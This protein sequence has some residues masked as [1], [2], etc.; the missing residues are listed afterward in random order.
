MK[1]I[2]TDPKLM[3]ESVN[4]YNKSIKSVKGTHPKHKNITI[5]DFSL[6]NRGPLED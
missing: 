5:V 1:D 3:H 2:F 4:K 6:N